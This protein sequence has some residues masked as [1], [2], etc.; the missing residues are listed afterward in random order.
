[1]GD[2][3]VDWRTATYLDIETTGLSAAEHIITLIATY[4]VTTERRGMLFV[5]DL[6]G[7]V[8]SVRQQLRDP[9]QLHCDVLEVNPLTE[10]VAYA[11]TLRGRDVVTYNG[12]D[13]DLPF[14]RAH[15]PDAT[16]AMA[17]WKHTDLL[18]DVMR[19][20]RVAGRITVPRL[21]LKSLLSWYDIDR[22]LLYQQFNRVDDG[23]DALRA[24]T[25]WQERHDSLQLSSMARYCLEDVRSTRELAVKLQE[26]LPHI[27]K[28]D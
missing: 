22:P 25:L 7:A 4:A 15:L 20:A 27:M 28:Q 10:F 18:A 12:R 24:W 14:I 23:V 26:Y 11:D 2:D 9:Q 17:E 21:G 6:N 16:D 19:P 1:M 3:R 8:E 13:F 5:N